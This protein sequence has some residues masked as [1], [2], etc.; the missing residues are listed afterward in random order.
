MGF[1]S[2]DSD[3]SSGCVL[4]VWPEVHDL[5]SLG[6]WTMMHTS[7]GGPAGT[8]WKVVYDKYYNPQNTDQGTIIM[9]RALVLF[10][11]KFTTEKQCDW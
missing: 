7:Q 8:E 6:K 3:S 11:S 2:K 10:S 1:M 9:K 5:M 4:V